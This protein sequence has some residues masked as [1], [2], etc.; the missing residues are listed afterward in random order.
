MKDV[1]DFHLT[2]WMTCVGGDSV[3]A[4]LPPFEREHLATSLDLPSQFE[5]VGLQSLI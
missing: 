3:N 1:D 5:G 2:T 4:D